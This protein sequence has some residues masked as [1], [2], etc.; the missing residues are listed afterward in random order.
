MSTFDRQAG[1]PRRKSLAASPRVGTSASTS[2]TPT[3][4]TE[5]VA[6]RAKVRL[7]DRLQ[8][9]LRGGLHHLGCP[10]CDD[11]V[12]VPHD[13]QAKT[14]PAGT[15]SPHPLRSHGSGGL[16]R[17]NLRRACGSTG[18]PATPPALHSTSPERM[19]RRRS[20]YARPEIVRG[21]KCPRVHARSNASARQPKGLRWLPSTRP[22]LPWM[23]TPGQHD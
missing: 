9:Q 2:P 4:G 6:A 7:P 23:Q 21:K 10:V 14:P 18:P 12:V 13:G 17:C 22:A 15:V 5:P 11:R 20:L 8:H 1:P 3:S 19:R 16:T